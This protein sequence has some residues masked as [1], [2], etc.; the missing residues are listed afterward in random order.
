MLRSYLIIV[1]YSLAMLS[2]GS[3]TSGF[4]ASP[5]RA[6]RPSLLR[7]DPHSLGI[8]PNDVVNYHQSIA[9]SSIS[10]ALAS[11]GGEWSF[12]W[13]HGGAPANS[14]PPS[15]D[16]AAA[17]ATMKDYFLPTTS[18]EVMNKALESAAQLKGDVISSADF[19]QLNQ[20]MPGAKAPPPLIPPTTYPYTEEIGKRE[21][22]WI[23]RSAD[24]FTRRLPTAI[25][26]YALLDFFVLPNQPDLLSDELED[27]RM[28]VARE[29][30]GGTTVRLGALLSVVF[31]TIFCE[32]AFY[33]P[34]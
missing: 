28:G 27:D 25:T 10:T 19:I 14:I 2:M 17:I 24:L 34:L 9:I 20:V 32:N 22:E 12:L 15:P 8:D 33:H 21:I 4:S 1:Q 6:R 23:A 31:L 11:Q 13:F 26:V 3:N 30:F 29:W 5:P 16:G 7:M 18:E